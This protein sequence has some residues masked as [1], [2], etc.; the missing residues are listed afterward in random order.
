MVFT[1]TAPC[2]CRSLLVV[3][4]KDKNVVQKERKVIAFEGIRR[5]FIFILFIERKKFFVQTQRGC[6][7][8]GLRQE[9]ARGPTETEVQASRGEFNRLRRKKKRRSR[10][11]PAQGTEG[12]TPRRK[13]EERSSA[14]QQNK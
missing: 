6:P 13:N 5:Y 14:D 12:Q 2:L 3:F 10:R 1:S 9:L 11:T 7:P 4:I 8:D